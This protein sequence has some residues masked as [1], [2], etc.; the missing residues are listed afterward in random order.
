MQIQ[1]L[2]TPVGGAIESEHRAL[3]L[4]IDM[5]KDI[6][7]HRHVVSM[8]ACCTKGDRLALVMEYVPYGNLQ[9]FL[10]KQRTST[11]V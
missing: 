7:Y 2:S 3:M 6:G 5:M 11:Q 10:K 9:S 1:S 8:L 4:E